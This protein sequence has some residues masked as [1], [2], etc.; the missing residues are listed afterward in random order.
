MRVD[1]DEN[2]DKD[3]F[4]TIKTAIGYPPESAWN[5]ISN[6]NFCKLTQIAKKK[7][8]FGEFVP[9]FDIKHK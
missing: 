8:N 2:L 1:L 6:A 9:H 7:D 3:V 5:K 4:H